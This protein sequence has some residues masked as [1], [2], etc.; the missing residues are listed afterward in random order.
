MSYS[1]TFQFDDAT[2]DSTLAIQH[3]WNASKYGEDLELVD[4]HWLSLPKVPEQKALE[5]TVVDFDKS[6]DYSDFCA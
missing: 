3:E 5:I 6:V 4:R 2:T 1:G